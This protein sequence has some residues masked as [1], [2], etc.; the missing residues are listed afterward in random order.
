MAILF[1]RPKPGSLAATRRSI[2]F[3]ADE[4][5]TTVATMATATTAG[6]ISVLIDDDCLES[7]L[8]EFFQGLFFTWFIS[9]RLDKMVSIDGQK[10]FADGSDGYCD[11]INGNGTRH[12]NDLTTR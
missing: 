1:G 5:Q 2:V 6:I 7:R 4:S 10:G 9:S 12:A 11:D 3:P 8:Q